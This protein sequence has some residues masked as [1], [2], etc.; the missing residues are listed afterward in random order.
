MQEKVQKKVRKRNWNMEAVKKLIL[1]KALI[2]VLLVMIVGIIIIE[3][4]FLQWRVVTDI[5]TQSAVKLIC[6][7]GIKFPLLIV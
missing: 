5:M 4:S 3:P 1:D 7:L 2:L 6:S